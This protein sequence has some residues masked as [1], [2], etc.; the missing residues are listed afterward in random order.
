MTISHADVR[1]LLEGYALWA[2][3]DP[4]RRQVEH[5]LAGC[6]DCRAEARALES[7]VD[8]LP[9]SLGERAP[10]SAL[11]ER[12]LRAAS[13]DVPARSRRS[14]RSF[15]S[16][17]VRPAWAL[18]LALLVVTVGATS[19]GLRMQQERD[20]YAS[21]AYS[22]SHGGRWWYMAGVADYQ[23]SG[24]TLI[25]PNADGRAF[26]LFHDLKPLA[27]GERY[28]VWMIR[29]DGSWVRASNF[30]PSGERLQRV[31]VPLA[32]A[33]FNQCAVS[34]ETTDSGPRQGTIA[35]QSRV[36]GQ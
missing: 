13:T 10:R 33:E 4:D 5:H 16:T 26:V 34:I 22:V 30:T 20:E 21:V 31:D 9:D 32:M 8:A 19:F 15:L 17:F 25:D 36:F 6:A 24:G 14:L 12:I 1:D 2:L 35:M 18:S 23:G 28:A 29:P 3:D 7:V 27:A 11:R